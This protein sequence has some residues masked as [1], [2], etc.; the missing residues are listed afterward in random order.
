MTNPFDNEEGS[1]FVLCND[2]NQHSLWRDFVDVPHGW[3]IV[4]GSASR[5]SC[6]DY[7][8]ENWTDLRPASLVTR[9]ADR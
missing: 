5:A 7:V 1:Y 2:E 3:Q 8:N 6:L 9:M 4:H